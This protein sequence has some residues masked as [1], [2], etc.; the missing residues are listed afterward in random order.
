MTAPKSHRLSI[1]VPAAIA[2]R[3]RELAEMEGRSISNLTA[4]LLR[5]AL[6]D[7]QPEPQ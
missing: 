7:G 3:L 4:S 2:E 6:R 1:V 5:A